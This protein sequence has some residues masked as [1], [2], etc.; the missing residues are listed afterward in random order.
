MTEHIGAVND[1]L[2]RFGAD[3]LIKNGAVRMT[4]ALALRDAGIQ[5][6]YELEGGVSDDVNVPQ[7]SAGEE[8]GLFSGLQ[9]ELE[10]AL[11]DS[12]EEFKRELTEEI[13]QSLKNDEELSAVTVEKIS[14][15][16]RWGRLNMFDEDELLDR[17][18]TRLLDRAIR[19]P[20][21][22][23]RIVSALEERRRVI[24]AKMPAMDSKVMKR[25][26]MSRLERAGRLYK[27]DPEAFRLRNEKRIKYLSMLDEINPKLA[28]RY[29]T[30]YKDV[31]SFYEQKDSGQ[32]ER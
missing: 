5:K 13:Y 30:V 24:E 29:R 26:R 10:W 16:T 8:N 1:S 6:P 22:A 12:A 25:I 15:L 9:A 27:N 4:S 17:L 19:H 14:S 28:E 32:T 18:E 3:E 31:L 7:E 11:G 21:R 20:E 23:E 2:R